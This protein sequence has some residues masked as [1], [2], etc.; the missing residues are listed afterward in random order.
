MQAKLLEIINEIKNYEKFGGGINFL[1]KITNIT[2]IS[3]SHNLANISHKTDY[4]LTR[5]RLQ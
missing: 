1:K 2:I 3:L 5:G 4:Y